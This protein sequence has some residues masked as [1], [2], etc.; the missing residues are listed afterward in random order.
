MGRYCVVGLMLQVGFSEP[1]PINIFHCVV[2]FHLTALDH[3][4]QGFSL[5]QPILDS[6]HS[7]HIVLSTSRFESSLS[8]C[9]IADKQ[10]KIHM[11]A[12][13]N[14]PQKERFRFKDFL[15]SSRGVFSI[16]KSYFTISLS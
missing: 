10:G 8:K 14:F 16:T 13:L 15:M 6:L 2:S 9:K 7:V 3:E 12:N 11:I 4:D 1:P 5:Q